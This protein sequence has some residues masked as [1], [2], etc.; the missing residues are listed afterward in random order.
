MCDAAGEPDLLLEAVERRTGGHG[1]RLEHL[2][3]DRFLEL[4]IEGAIDDPHAAGPENF[5]HLVAA[6]EDRARTDLVPTG[7][8]DRRWYGV[9]ALRRRASGGLH[10]VFHERGLGFQVLDQALEGLGE[11]A[12]LVA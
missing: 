10:H 4:A 12:D 3:G 1:F 7:G 8:A 9:Q 11:N 5:L 2:D 6:R